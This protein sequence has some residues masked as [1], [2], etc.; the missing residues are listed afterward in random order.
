MIFLKIH[1]ASDLWS[2]GD[3]N[4]GPLACHIWPDSR[5]PWLTWHGSICKIARSGG[6]SRVV[7]VRTVVS[8]QSRPALRGAHDRLLQNASMLSHYVS[9]QANPY[10]LYRSAMRV[11]GG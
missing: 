2:Y 6:L 5:I 1:M 7:V 9:D 10:I 8:A 4:S 3:S 11:V